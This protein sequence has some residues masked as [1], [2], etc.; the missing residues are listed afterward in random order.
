MKKNLGFISF[1]NLAGYLGNTILF[2]ES[3]LRRNNQEVDIITHFNILIFK[4]IDNQEV[5][6]I[7]LFNIFLLVFS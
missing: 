2:H 6:I 5:G 1:I 4:Y 3:K 7:I